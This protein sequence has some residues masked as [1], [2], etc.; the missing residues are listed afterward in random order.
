MTDLLFDTPW[1]LPALIA[2]A[3]VVLFVTGNNRLEPRVK[4][5]GLAAV[6]LA[7]LLVAVSYL[8]D[9]P[10]ETAERRSREL[11]DAFER[12][13]W[14]AMTAVLDPTATVSVLTFRVYDNRDEI[15]KAAEAAH[16]RYGFKSVNVL[17]MGAEQADTVITV[18]MV[19]LSE[20]DALG[21][22]LNSEWQFEWQ[23]TADGWALVDVRALKI[24]QSTGDQVRGMFPGK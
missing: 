24:G 23:R 12:A 8:V 14:P 16:G 21:R 13:D 11:V 19:L 6:G 2:A 9:T 17:T 3:G 1:W 20:Q 7:L 5:A 22:T 15:M 4:Y 18:T 10:I